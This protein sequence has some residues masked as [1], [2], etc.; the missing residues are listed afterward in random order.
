MVNL[1]KSMRRLVFFLL[2]VVFVSGCDLLLS[3]KVRGPEDALVRVRAGRVPRFFD[4][5]D[6]ASLKEAVQRSIEYF[7]TL[8]QDRQVIFGPDTYTVSQMVSSLEAFLVFVDHALTPEEFGR[9]VSSGFHVYQSVGQGWRRQVLFTGY[10]EPV[11]KGS[12][13]YDEHHPY[14]LYRRP[15]ELVGVRLGMFNSRFEGQSIMGKLEGDRLVPFYTRKEIDGDGVLE[16]RG[17]EIAWLT[18]RVDRYFLQIQG[19]GLV[20]LKDGTYLRVNY[21]ASNGRPYRSIGK[22][23]IDRG[24]VAREEMSMQR[25][26][27]YLSD[28]PEEVTEILFH[29]PSYT[30]FRIAEEGPLGN[31]RVPLTS[32]RSIA[33]DSRLFPKGGL[34]FVITE[35]PVIGGGGEITEWKR[36]SRFVVNQ[37]TG[38]AIRG[39]ARVDLF[40]GEGEIAEISAGHMKQKGK[41][42]FLMK[43]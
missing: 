25:I 19:S 17:Y 35:K 31:I 39:P 18:D 29:D 16:G 41:L 10:Y 8:P 32:G 15:D 34:A 33:T 28:H 36:F 24:E 30:F 20:R 26:R 11:V 37:D 13:T 12:L 43:K 6:K 40:W 3:R 1:S 4:D 22:L 9:L 14:P 27:S 7:N 42:F 38:G 5:L 23:L 21:D 2:V